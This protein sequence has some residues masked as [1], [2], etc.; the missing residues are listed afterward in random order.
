MAKD[1]KSFVDARSATQEVLRSEVVPIMGEITG[2]DI[3]EKLRVAEFFVK[4]FALV[5]DIEV[6]S[7]SMF[8][9]YSFVF[10]SFIWSNENILFRALLIEKYLTI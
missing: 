10:S 1:V 9:S 8:S 3:N 2:R 6:S 5:G 4:A 7:D